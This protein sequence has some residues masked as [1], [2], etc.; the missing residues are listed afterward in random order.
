MH[1]SG[2]QWDVDSPLFR[3]YQEGNANV[4][5]TPNYCFSQIPPVRRPLLTEVR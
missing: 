4:I 1:I 2:N 5:I 3:G